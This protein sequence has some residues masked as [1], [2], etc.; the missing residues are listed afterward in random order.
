MNGPAIFLLSPANCGGK[1]AA[2]L[3][4]PEAEFDLA[5]RVNSPGGAPL[6]EVFSFV[7]GLYFRGK[8]AYSEAFARPPA[9]VPG[10]LIITTGRGLVAPDVSVDTSDIRSFSEVPIDIREPRYREP[11]LADASRLRDTLPPEAQVVLLGSVATSKYVE[12]LLDLF[13]RRLCFPEPFIGMGD[14]QRG[15]LMLRAV[16]EGV[17]LPYASAEGAVRSLA[18]RGGRR[19]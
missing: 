3:L 18:A 13:G 2:I 10:A 15:A 12:V 14:M 17:E 9:G 5:A 16:R 8:M 6:G 1:R 4:R 19:T 11:L 7:S